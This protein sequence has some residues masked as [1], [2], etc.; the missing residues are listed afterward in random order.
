MNLTNPALISGEALRFAYNNVHPAV[1]MREA[2]W[3]KSFNLIDR[4]NV[5]KAK[6]FK[7][8]DGQY[9]RL[10][11]PRQNPMAQILAVTSATANVIVF[12]TTDPNFNLFR[13]G[14]VI[15]DDN[16]FAEGRV[17]VATPG[18]FTIE[19][20]FNPTSFDTATQFLAGA[21]VK[22]NHQRSIIYG[23][24]GTKTRFWERVE[25]LDYTET[26]NET[27]TITRKEGFDTYRGHDGAA[28]YTSSMQERM[29]II[30]SEIQRGMR[31]WL[32][33]GGLKAGTDGKI[34]GTYG[35]RSAIIN[36]NGDANRSSGYY[37]PLTAPPDVTTVES[38]GEQMASKNGAS[39]QN[40]LFGMG[41]Q[42]L[43]SFQ[44]SADIRNMITNTGIR[45]TVGGTDVTGLDVY[46]WRIAGIEYNIT[47]LPF[48]DDAT[49]VPSWM[50][51][52]VFGLDLTA[53]PA[54]LEDGSMGTD[55]A[56]QRI[57][58]GSS[59]DDSV[60]YSV[61]PGKSGAPGQSASMGGNQYNIASQLIDG[62]TL[63]VQIDDGLSVD[64]EGFAL[65]EYQP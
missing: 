19:A 50:T 8:K 33:N 3:F 27:Y 11:Q 60:I 36:P 10:R 46:I 47:H 14:D 23:S 55:N 4:L 45:N 59:S 30:D 57:T 17:I 13:E 51:Y 21:T 49:R 24:G 37:M 25:Q 29:M 63:N 18:T 2:S 31:Y 39:R 32:G 41:R 9:V 58:F 40:F 26:L 48:L 1:M 43:K 34:S 65:A 5:G 16:T 54:M 62:Y 38:M 20:Q 44:R 28:Y 35:L 56:I 52:S 22:F 7:S 15:T 61:V 53:V 12:T 6:P 42:A 64:A